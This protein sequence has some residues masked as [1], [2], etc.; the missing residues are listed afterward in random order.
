M[1]QS[2]TWGAGVRGGACV[3]K[4]VMHLDTLRGIGSNQSLFHVEQVFEVFDFGGD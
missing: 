2:L 1:R 3:D 4:G